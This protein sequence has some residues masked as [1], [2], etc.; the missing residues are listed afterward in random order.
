[1]RAFIIVLL[2]LIHTYAFSQNVSRRLPSI[3]AQTNAR[4][5]AKYLN[6]PIEVAE[7]VSQDFKRFYTKERCWLREVDAQ[8]YCFRLAGYKER[9]EP[10]NQRN[11]L[12]LS[13]TMIGFDSFDELGG[14]SICTG[15]AISYIFDA[16]REIKL[17]KKSKFLEVGSSG[18]GPTDWTLS[19]ANGKGYWITANGSK[20]YG[21]SSCSQ[22]YCITYWYLIGEDHLGR[23]GLLVNGLSSTDNTGAFNDQKGVKEQ[24]Y[25]FIGDGKDSKEMPTVWANH[26]INKTRQ[27]PKMNKISLPY[28][29]TKGRYLFKPTEQD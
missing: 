9:G 2:A 28:S 11:Y 6:L 29:K 16:D 13:G 7:I 27:K 14:C 17:L 15:L 5:I 4:H 3:D 24:W 10:G 8:E 20:S 18:Y 1:M 25:F 19:F 22:G 26:Y 12:I 23:I 21:L